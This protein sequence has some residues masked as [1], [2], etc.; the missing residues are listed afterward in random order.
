[1]VSTISGALVQVG[2]FPRVVTGRS[3]CTFKSSFNQAVYRMVE[4][5]AK[6]HVQTVAISFDTVLRV[7]SSNAVM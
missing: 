4:F 5:K 3:Y 7:G 1:M 2:F 6:D